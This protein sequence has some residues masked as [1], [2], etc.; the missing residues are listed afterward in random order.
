MK[1]LPTSNRLLFLATFNL[2]YAM[3]SLIQEVWLN[4]I[5]SILNFF[6]I[7]FAFA[8]IENEIEEKQIE[9]LGLEV[10]G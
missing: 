4:A 6:I 2:A 3:W 8:A 5:L 1:L 10:I 7:M 9:E